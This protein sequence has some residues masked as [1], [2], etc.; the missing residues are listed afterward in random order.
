[1]TDLALVHDLPPRWDGYP[2]VWRGWQGVPVIMCH[3]PVNDR[4]VVCG[5]DKDPS[6]NT[7]LVGESTDMTQRD[8]RA[9]DAAARLANRSGVIRHHRRSW[10][11][12]TAF[13]CPDCGHDQVDD[14]EHMWDLD[15]SD[16][17]DAGSWPT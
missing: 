11:R 16:Y 4:C 8:V 10:V 15:Q 2:V 17:T 13:R 6:L 9:D 3:R 1:M 5:G 7:G 12:L 14:G